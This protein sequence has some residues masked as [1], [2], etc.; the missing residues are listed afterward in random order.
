MEELKYLNPRQREM[1]LEEL[2]NLNPEKL[3]YIQFERENSG[4]T[5]S[6]NEYRGSKVV[7]VDFRQPSSFIAD[8][9]IFNKKY[10]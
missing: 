4:F 9:R 3:Y 8:I 2:K 6:I 1:L 7:G 10:N 5:Y